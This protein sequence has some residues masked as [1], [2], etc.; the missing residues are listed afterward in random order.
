MT[1]DQSRLH[2]YID[3]GIEESLTLEYKAAAAL[4]KT[5]PKKDEI[6]KDVSAMA[7]AAGGVLIY[8]IAEHTESDK[9]HLPARIDPLDR[10]EYPK[11]WLEQVISNIRPRLDGIV[12]HPVSLT[13]DPNAVVYVVEIPQS[14][15]AHQANSK[16]Y[17][18][19]FN[20]ESVPMEDYEIRDIMS[21]SRHPHVEL[22]FQIAQRTRTRS[23]YM[24]NGQT[25]TTTYTLLVRAK[26]VGRVYAQ[27]LN[28]FI[29]LPDVLLPPDD[30]QA[31]DLV[32]I[33]GVVYCEFYE[34]NTVRDVV[35]VEMIGAH[36]YQKY[37][38]ARFDPLLPSLSLTWEIE[39]SESFAEFDLSALVLH[40]KT[41][42]D[43]APV[44]RGAVPVAAIPIVD[45][46]AVSP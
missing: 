28:S 25:H 37:G 3:Q 29:R 14:D 27:Y 7:N 24:S 4:E 30:Y 11:E 9:R 6:T 42:A 18:K 19:R 21:R 22:S 36:P 33:D 8:G 20:F 31:R 38:P 10:T 41:H 46:R 39:L 17:Y 2:Q 26:N 23:N 13:G 15:T 40:W 1:W 34:D 16:R 45:Q 5:Q 35:D 12:I 32:K 44:Q 43:N